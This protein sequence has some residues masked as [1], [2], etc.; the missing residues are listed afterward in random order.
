MLLRPLSVFFCVLD[1]LANPGISLKNS[2]SPLDVRPDIIS[3]CPRA[4]HLLGTHH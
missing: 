4:V 1:L 3:L 2:P